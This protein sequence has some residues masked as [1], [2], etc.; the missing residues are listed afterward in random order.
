[1]L[2]TLADVAFLDGQHPEMPVLHSSEPKQLNFLFPCQQPQAN[3]NVWF[4][5]EYEYRWHESARIDVVIIET[6]WSNG[7]VEENYDAM[8]A[9]AASTS[10]VPSDITP[11]MSGVPPL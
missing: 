1:M 9:A 11:S 5:R 4:G 2:G 6:L 8:E 7:G 3:Y 10:G